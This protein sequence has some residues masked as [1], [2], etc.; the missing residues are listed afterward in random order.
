[1]RC[2]PQ[3]YITVDDEYQS[4]RVRYHNY[5]FTDTTSRPGYVFLGNSGHVVAECH[6]HP[7]NS[8][9]IVKTVR[10]E[11][12]TDQDNVVEE[13]FDEE[14]ICAAQKLRLISA[15]LEEEMQ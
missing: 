8:R 1:M 7:T 3:S 6:G 10:D 11:I 15:Q 4:S 5:H 14:K 9:I 12:N 13:E 2:E